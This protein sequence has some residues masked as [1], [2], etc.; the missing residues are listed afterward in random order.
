MKITT[1]VADVLDETLFPEL[2][3]A[4]AHLRG[5]PASSELIARARLIEGTGHD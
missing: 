4:R 1:P 2:A 5:E 3:I